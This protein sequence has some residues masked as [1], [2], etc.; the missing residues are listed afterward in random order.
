MIHVVALLQDDEESQ[1]HH[2]VEVVES[3]ILTIPIVEVRLLEDDDH[4]VM[5]ANEEEELLRL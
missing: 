3:R 2:L 4:L 1:A 5:M